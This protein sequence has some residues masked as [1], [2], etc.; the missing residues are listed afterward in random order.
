MVG[1]EH[2]SC[3]QHALQHD[4]DHKSARQDTLVGVDRL[5]AHNS[6]RCGID[7][8]SQRRKRV[9]YKIDPKD[10]D[11]QQRSYHIADHRRK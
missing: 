7:T 4:T 2:Q 8:Q 5:A 9:G 6:A 1:R 3:N 11:R 10:M